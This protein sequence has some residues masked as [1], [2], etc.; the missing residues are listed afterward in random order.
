MSKYQL[1]PSA[2]LGTQGVAKEMGK[3]YV[4]MQNP[5]CW[6]QKSNSSDIDIQLTK[7]TGVSTVDR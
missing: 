1:W 4:L 7:D 3:G 5:D 6:T 2:M